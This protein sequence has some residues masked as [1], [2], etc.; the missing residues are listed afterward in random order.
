MQ[1]VAGYNV[2]LCLLAMALAPWLMQHVFGRDF[3][4]A[5]AVFVLLVGAYA[6]VG[7]SA[8]FGAWLLGRGRTLTILAVNTLWAVS[9]LALFA[10]VFLPLGAFGAGL[11]S[12]L[13]YWGA[14]ALYA[15]FVAPRHGLPWGSYLPAVLVSGLALALG[16]ALQL[17]PAVPSALALLTNVVL[18]ALVFAR[19]GWPSLRD[20][21]L[22]GRV[23]R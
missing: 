3:A 18:A 21:G 7:P 5:R 8:L 23:A 20:S 4:P 15:L 11:A 1:Q 9:T 19:W 6:A 2:A 22:L 17:A 10:F 13:A 16:G 14:L 12:V